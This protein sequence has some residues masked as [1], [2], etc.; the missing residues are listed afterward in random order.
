M[1]KIDPTSAVPTA[2]Q[3]SPAKQKLLAQ[4]QRGQANRLAAQD[5]Q[6]NGQPNGKATGGTLARR[7]QQSALPLSYAQQ[8]LWFLDQM[9]AGATYHVPQPLRFSGVLNV[10]ALQWAL[11]TLVQR[12]ESLR[13]IF[14]IVAG[15]P[16]Q[17]IL[18]AL[19]LP[20]ALLPLLPTA[21]VERK[22][23]LQ[24]QLKALVEQ[25]FDLATGP[26]CRANLCSL[27][28]DDHLLLITMHH[29]ITDGWS[30]SI[31]INELNILYRAFCA[32]QPDPLPPLAIQYGDF[33]V[34]QQQWLQ[35]ERL[36]HL[37]NYWQ[38]QLVDAPDLLNLPI[39][40][41]RPAVQSYRGA[42]YHEPLPLS[43]RQQL[44]SLATEQ[45]AT[46]FMVLQ[47]AF[48]IL[49]A[50][51]S[52]QEDI[53]IGTP[54]AGRNRSE[55]EP[56]M[57]LFVNTL[58]LRTR[59]AGNPLFC[60]LL[61]QVRQTT[62][63]AYEQQDLPFDRLVEALR[64]V[65]TL[66]HS[67][68]FQVMLNMPNATGQ[69]LP[70]EG[71]VPTV[72]DLPWQ[73][74]AFD[75]TLHIWETA[76]G[77]TC[78]WE[79][80]TDLFDAAT[81][82]QMA[83]NL[84]SMLE[85]I[86][87]EPGQ[88]IHDLQILT[89]TEAQRLLG[90]WTQTQAPYPHGQCLHSLF[91]AQAAC[92]PD[93]LAA[94][95]RQQQLTYQ[96][97]EQQANQLAHVL[98]ARGIG[99]DVLVGIYLERSLAVLVAML[100]IL[101]AGG[102]YV[103]LDPEYPQE[104]LHFMLHD[105]QVA[106]VIT[107]STLAA[108]LADAQIPR[109][110]LDQDAA[111]LAQACITPPVAVAQP[112]HLAYVIYT[113]GSTGQP[114]G[115][116]IPHRALVN[117]CWGF[118]QRFGL[119][120]ADRVLQFNS[121]SFDV[122]GQELYPT[123]LV[124][125]TVVLRPTWPF[126]LADLMALVQAEGITVLDLPVEYW[127][128]WVAQLEQWPVPPSV[129]LVVV[130]G[131][132]ASRTHWARWQALAG[133]QVAW[134]VAYGVTEATIDS[135]FSDP[136]LTCLGRTDAVPAG[137]PLPN[138]QVYLLDR[139]SHPVPLGVAGEIHLGGDSIARGYLNRPALTD[140]R[141][142]PNPFG[143]GRLYKTGDLAR[144]LPDGNLE[145][146]G[147]IDRQVKIR[148]FRV[149]VGE[150]ERVLQQHPAVQDAMV[151]AQEA[152]L[153]S[154]RLI[155]YFIVES[156][157]PE[158]TPEPAALR[159]WLK[160]HLPEYM[161]PVAFVPVAAWPRTPSGKV[162]LQALPQPVQATGVGYQPPHTATEVA[163]AQLWSELLGMPRI[164]GRDNFFDLGGH[165]LLVTRLIYLIEER[166]AVRPTIH[167]LFAQPTLAALAAHLDQL[168]QTS[169]ASPAQTGVT[170]DFYAEARLDPAIVLPTPGCFVHPATSSAIFLT[171]ATGFL[172]AALL[173]ELLSHTHAD[174]YCLVRAQGA[175]EGWQRLR[176][177]L[178]FY[179]QN[180]G[181]DQAQRIKP[182]L[183]D[184]GQPRLGLSEA[185]F[186]AFAERIDIIYHNGAWVNHIYPYSELK[187]AN[188]GGTLEILRL[189]ATH[190]TK[191][192]HFVSTTSIFSETGLAQETDFPVHPEKIRNG[193]GES[194]W[195]AERMVVAAQA[196]GLPA[197][198]YRPTRIVVS[199]GQG[200]INE[201][202]A[203]MRIIKGC[204]QLG[205]A[206]I[207][208]EFVDNLTPVDF[209]SRAIVHL[210]LQPA[211]LGKAFHLV[212]PQNVTMTAIMRQVQAYGYALTFMPSTAWREEVLRRARLDPNISLHPFLPML[213]ANNVMLPQV[214]YDCVNTLTG[215]QN[216]TITCPPIAEC[217]WQATLT[218]L[219]QTGYLPDP[220][221]SA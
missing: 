157:A 158:Q 27:A 149:E 162:D 132:K 144:Y 153:G 151:L 213:T 24:A 129:R 76:Q 118:A 176:R 25:P 55:I 33:V 187:A 101:K 20:L 145:V 195:V 202:D 170:V 89:A 207:M 99:P 17:V 19:D 199:Q 128:E 71:F 141:F 47:A 194:K 45:G 41:A 214:T 43:L 75:L 155:A 113:S 197:A 139:Y 111:E 44:K 173:Q 85:S 159:A 142:I 86:V 42:V 215:L 2:A 216:T 206:P 28:T 123:W 134:H 138:T 152:Q 201:N 180:D 22:A 182:V 58:A 70:E 88:R 125:A 204:I 3:L 103:P 148:G 137:R 126:A 110:Y 221:R 198:I 1:P 46:L 77:L 133:E 57:G 80:S 174:I 136:A 179:T 6:Q 50:R 4:W 209:V 94:R 9:G 93:A 211:T 217:W 122:S 73:I 160:D 193:Y 124:G 205:I 186:A 104:R 140:E 84:R 210:S 177:Q 119:T 82:V 18:P 168:Q 60:D 120:A 208:D 66:S 54:I 90:E 121:F 87:A 98:Q 112:E 91:A 8:R 81:I 150:I 62:L 165:S 34:W 11:Q 38:T 115:I 14:P 83:G 53:V 48:V 16:R 32:D 175:E 23:A 95:Y 7:T 196:R 116:M 78:T 67:P 96:Q 59:L 219:V 51:L 5:G 127:H 40:R 172:G 189:A 39:D 212:N 12:H 31:F 163:L 156:A 35:G 106:L 185:D 63:A 37:L 97:L 72:L 218:D 26:L 114:K 68:L 164:S 49:L 64:P 143:A 65:R 30:I 15:Q 167:S 161:I 178:A 131:N 184:L 10:P 171:G 220:A 74:T 130:G 203:L 108:T 117:H 107:D 29:I 166:L 192:V 92:T 102:A 61:A 190:K 200:T 13:T 56:L 188:V 105:A 135:T 181:G 109:L 191:P 79:Y 154:N 169:A 21:P 183:G 146:L 36:M 100:G 52:S 69:S 147:R